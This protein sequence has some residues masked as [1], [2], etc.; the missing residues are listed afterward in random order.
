MKVDEGQWNK[1]K[2]NEDNEWTMKRQW[3]EMNE[4][5]LNDGKLRQMKVDEKRW[6]KMKLDEGEWR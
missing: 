6:R 3:K 2:D 5:K 1:I 4:D